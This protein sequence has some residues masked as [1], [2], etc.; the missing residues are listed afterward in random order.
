[1]AKFWYPLSFSALDRGD[2]LRISGKALR[3]RKTKSSWQSTVKISW[4]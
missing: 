4:S 1:M 2:P 3:I